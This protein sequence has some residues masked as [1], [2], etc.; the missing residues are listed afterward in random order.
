LRFSF[1]FSEVNERNRDLTSIEE[2]LQ[3]L[4]SAH[5]VLVNTRTV[6]LIGVIIGLTTSGV[7][8]TLL[9]FGVSGVMYVGG[10]DLRRLFWPSSI[11]LVTSWRSTIPGVMIT[12]SAVVID[13]LLYMA[14]AYAILGLVRLFRRVMA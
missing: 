5:G 10:T 13:C 6:L 14:I 9:W 4:H 12:I 1:G 2:R 3:S 7:V 8:L 11:V